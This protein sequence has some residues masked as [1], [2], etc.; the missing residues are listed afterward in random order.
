GLSALE[1]SPSTSPS[2]LRL[3][4]HS[5]CQEIGLLWTLR[6]LLFEQSI[7]FTH[8]DPLRRRAIQV[9]SIAASS[10][11]TSRLHIPRPDCESLPYLRSCTMSVAKPSNHGGELPT[12]GR[13]QLGIRRPDLGRDSPSRNFR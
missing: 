10:V 13:P 9:I 12:I 6:R 5:Q 4:V 2:Q 1:V 11:C 7:L 8:H 3:Q